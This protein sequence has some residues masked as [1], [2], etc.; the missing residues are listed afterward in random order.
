MNP[1]T[2]HFYFHVFQFGA[3]KNVQNPDKGFEKLNQQHTNLKKSL[4][5]W[6]LLLSC[7]SAGSD[8]RRSGYDKFY[9]S[10]Q[11]DP[12]VRAWTNHLVS[13]QQTQVFI[14]VLF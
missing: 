13:F 4:Q 6:D 11:M 8:E 14:P 7:L 2:N 10:W 12:K 9:I 5:T 3:S 1:T